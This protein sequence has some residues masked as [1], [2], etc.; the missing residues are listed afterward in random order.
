MEQACREITLSDTIDD[1]ISDDYKARFK[2]EYDQLKIRMIGL[3][4]TLNQ[5]VHKKL[6]WEPNSSYNTLNRQYQTMLIYSQILETRAQEE[7]I[8]L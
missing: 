1:M 6:T 2:A 8:I 3:Q 7:N 4:K 5:Y